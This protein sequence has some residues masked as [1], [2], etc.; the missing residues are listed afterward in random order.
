MIKFTQ[1]EKQEFN[2][3]LK[4]NTNGITE[5]LDLTTATEIKVC[6]K[7]ESTVVT[8]LLSLAE[9]SIVG[10][11]TLGKITID[12]LPADTDT[13]PKTSNGSIE[14]VITFSATDVKKVIQTQAFMVE[15]KLC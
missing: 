10:S 13:M 9:V 8:K 1:G 14:V 4:T 7:A 6:F 11:A 12:L 15:Q 2:I 3:F 5:P